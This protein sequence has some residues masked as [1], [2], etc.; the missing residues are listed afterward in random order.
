[1]ARKPKEYTVHVTHSYVHDPEA[2]ERGLQLWATFL[3]Q[4]L[5]RRMSE[6]RKAK[7]EA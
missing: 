1:M 2:V 6:E 4:H 5:I 7:Q 3:A